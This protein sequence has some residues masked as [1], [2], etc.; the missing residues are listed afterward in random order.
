MLAKTKY[1]ALAITLVLSLTQPLG[2][3]ESSASSEWK[4]QGGFESKDWERHWRIGETK[5]FGW[6]NLE[7]IH[8]SAKKT[9]YFLRVRYPKGSFS[10]SETKKLGRKVGGAQFLSQPQE[11]F[12]V[13]EVRLQYKVKFR[14]NFD[15][16]KGGKLPGLYGG[17][18][19]SGGD[20][21]DGT[22]GFSVRLMWR[23]D[24]AGEVYAYLPT[25]VGYGTSIGRGNWYFTPGKW[26][27]LDLRLRLNDPAE[28][29]GEI[30]LQVD[31]ESVVQESGLTFRTVDTLHLD[32]IFFSTFFG[33]SD[34]SWATPETTSIFFD[35]FWLGT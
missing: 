12:P 2:V 19:N 10:P 3:L 8:S 20:I 24:G 13:D 27:T 9:N 6:E 23:E 16:V 4:W 31:G 30:E 25:S 28:A 26:H 18:A 33:G 35:D 1:T 21:P 5:M 14:K 34:A 7:I 17:T 32:G 22:D 29:N 15:F 11:L